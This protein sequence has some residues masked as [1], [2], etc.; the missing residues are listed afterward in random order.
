MGIKNLDDGRFQ[1]D[2]RNAKNKRLIRL[3]DNAEDAK[4]FESDILKTLPPK[5]QRNRQKKAILLSVEQFILQVITAE[6]ELLAKEEAKYGTILRWKSNVAL[7]PPWLKTK[8][9]T[10]VSESDCEKFLEYLQKRKHF[11]SYGAGK[12]SEE[13][14]GTSLGLDSIAGKFGFLKAMLERAVDKRLI[15]RNPADRVKVPKSKKKGGRDGK[16]IADSDRLKAHEVVRLLTKAEETLPPMLFVFIAVLVLAGLRVGEARNLQLQDL[17]F[18]NYIEL[19]K[20]P[21]RRPQIYIERADTAGRLGR[22]KTWAI[23]LVDMVPALERILK[24]YVSTLPSQHPQTWLFPSDALP[25]V[26]TERRQ[27][28]EIS[29]QNY[30]ID[31]DELG[32]SL[33]SDQIKDPW[34]KLMKELKFGRPI[35]LLHLRHTFATLA[36]LAGEDLYYV[37]KQLGHKTME[38]TQNTYALWADPIARGYFSKAIEKLDLPTGSFRDPPPTVPSPGPHDSPVSPALVDRAG[39]SSDHGKGGDVSRVISPGS[40]IST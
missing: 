24:S 35:T 17:Q 22:P 32:W 5:G 40:E 9:I 26:G 25:E 16:A 29:A 6:E 33:S 21:K 14:D 8:D 38:L 15:L 31:L 11:Q 27:Q 1:V 23:R 13:V 20:R 39:F 4:I 37:S 2:V 7:F 19:G 36:L 12:P 18:E 10:K 28:I 30:N 3:F 34:Q